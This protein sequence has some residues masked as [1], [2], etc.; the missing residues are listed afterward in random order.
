MA[1]KKLKKIYPAKAQKGEAWEIKGIESLSGPNREMLKKDGYPY[2]LPKK[3]RKG[4]KESYRPFSG[5]KGHR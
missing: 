3:K 1:K 5:Y 2:K 4:P